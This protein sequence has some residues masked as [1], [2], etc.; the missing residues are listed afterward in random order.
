MARVQSAHCWNKA[1]SLSLQFFVGHYL[2]NFFYFT[3][4]Q[5]YLGFLRK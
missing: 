4:N 5:H 2:P 1:N 3:Y